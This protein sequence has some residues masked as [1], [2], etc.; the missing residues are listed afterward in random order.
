MYNMFMEE[1]DTITTDTA[2]TN[3]A[4]LTTGS[5]IMGVQTAP[6]PE[7]AAKAINQLSTKQ[8]LLMNQMAALLYTNFP[9]P[10]Q[11]TNTMHHQSNNSLFQCSR[12]S[13]RPQRAGSTLVMEAVAEEGVAD[14][15]KEVEVGDAIN[16]H[17]LQTM[18]VYK[19]SGALDGA[20]VAVDLFHRRQGGSLR[21][22]LHLC[23]QMHKTLQ[24][25]SPT[26]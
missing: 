5:T 11:K 15:D 3:I 8:T 10:L 18:A 20:K 25:L 2:M 19:V 9:P 22:R 12:H 26:Q 4:A 6:I 23:P 21:R 24:C 14:K 13:P 1:D 17:C 7:L 16:A